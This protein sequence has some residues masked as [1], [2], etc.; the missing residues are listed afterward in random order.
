MSTLGRR[1]ATLYCTIPCYLVGYIIVGCS[2]SYIM[3]IGGRFLTGM[4]LGMTLTIPNVY[5]V[6]VTDPQF[7][8][9][10]GVLPNL[11]CQLGIFATYITGQYLDWSQLAFICAGLNLI[12]APA[13]YYIPE[14]PMY[15]LSKGQE[16]QAE[17]ALEM[18]DIGFHFE[19][20]IQNHR[21][22]LLKKNKYKINFDS[23]FDF[24]FS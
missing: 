23:I 2:T 12:F 21:F 10:L 18:L 4:G 3:L 6:E 13:V 24:S 5:L 17:K 16:D 9:V 1:G 7:R 22:S 15:L 20:S 19:G 8:G 14:S 11:L